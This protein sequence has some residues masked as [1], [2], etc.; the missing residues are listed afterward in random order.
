MVISKKISIF[1]IIVFIGLVLPTASH[2]LPDPERFYR[3]LILDSQTGSPYQDVRIPLIAALSEYGY[4]VGENLQITYGIAENDVLAG[5]LILKEEL[6]KKFDVIYA[7]GTVATIS[8]KHV[9]WNSHIPVVFGAPTDPIGLGV[10][11]NFD[12][13]PKANF[14]GVS[15]P[16]PVRSRFLFLRQLMPDAHRF[17]LIYADMPQSESYNRWIRELLENDPE[18]D[19]IEVIFRAV[20]LV[21]GNNGDQKMAELAIPF[22][23]EL[24]DKVDAFLKPNDQLGARENFAKTVESYADKPLIGLVKNDVVSRWG[25]TAVVYPCLECIG[26]QVA[27]MIRGL[28]EDYQVQQIEPK[29]PARY[30]YA[31]DLTKTKHFGIKVPVGILQLSGKNIVQ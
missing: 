1:Q 17:G 24:N 30:G 22:I 27:V 25:A 4:R 14:T 15:Y 7:G 23:Q 11:D 9:M 18:F 10:I 31:V 5:E 3:L 21:T 8:A 28:F 6:S 26:R 19:D 2:S 16:V 20:P 13:P 29:W 12:Q